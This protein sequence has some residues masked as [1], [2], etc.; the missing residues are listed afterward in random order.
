MFCRNDRPKYRVKCFIS[1]PKPGAMLCNVL[2][3]TGVVDMEL[4]P[5]DVIGHPDL[6]ICITRMASLYKSKKVICLLQEHIQTLQTGL[7]EKVYDEKC[8]FKRIVM[9][10]DLTTCHCGLRLVYFEK[11][12]K[13]EERRLMKFGDSLGFKCPMYIKRFL[14]AVIDRCYPSAGHI[15]SFESSNYIINELN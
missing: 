13:D 2:F 14:A 4:M 6:G 3:V 9:P 12:S 11:K 7:T 8:D 1:N 15:W 10:I 5:G